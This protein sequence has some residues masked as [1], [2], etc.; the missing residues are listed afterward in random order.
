MLS[1]TE[2]DFAENIAEQCEH[3]GVPHIEARGIQFIGR[4]GSSSLDGVCGSLSWVTADDFQSML[5]DGEFH[6]EDNGDGTITV[7]HDAFYTDDGD[8]ITGYTHIEHIY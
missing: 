4:D 7:F 2:I 1:L 6:Y 5:A 3:A 8:N